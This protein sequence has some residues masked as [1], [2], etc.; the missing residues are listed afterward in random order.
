MSPRRILWALPLSLAVLAGVVH[1]AP[2]SFNSALDIAERQSPDLAAKTAQI[3]AAQSAA[4]P[5]GAL[6]D[7]T[8]V[9]GVENYP[10]SGMDSWRLNSDFMTMQKIG[11]MQA[12]PNAAKRRAREDVA[13]A[14]VDVAEAQ[15]LIGRLKVRR[16][17]ALAWLSIYFAERKVALLDELDQENKVLAEAVKAQIASGR[18]QV[19]DAVMPKQEAVQL[20]DR[21]DDLTRDVVNARANLRHFVG[22]EA[23][24]PLAGDPPVFPI[25]TVHLHEHLHHHP[26]LQAFTSETRKAEAELREADSMKKS[27]WGVELDFQRRSP[28]FGNMVS[29]QFTF[30]LPVS[31][32]TRQE[33]LIAA[34]QQALVRIDAERE[35]MLRE[36]TNELDSELADYA[37]L[38]RQL[39]RARHTALSLAQEKMALQ[40]ASYKAGKGDLT[41]VLAARREL[42]DQR[43]KIID[44]EGQRETLAAQFYFAYGEGAQ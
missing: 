35:G 42:I 44:L 18:G 20:A 26:E 33:P 13:T 24:E 34:K 28:Q 5:A 39:D 22:T 16:D 23:D 19:V 12:F 40:T 27:D 10:V 31:P 43:M 30:D 29:M 7:P 1:A 32:S 36:H 2:L 11:V 38:S 41:A 8:L 37:A 9:A 6:P 4:I 17:T 3:S 15:R 21:R 25:D 14:N